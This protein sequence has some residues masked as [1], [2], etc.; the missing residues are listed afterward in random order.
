MKSYARWAAPAR[1]GAAFVASLLAAGLMGCATSLRSMPSKDS[2]AILHSLGGGV[3]DSRRSGKVVLVIGGAHGDEPSGAQAARRLAAAPP[4]RNGL[5]LVLP[6]ANP[7]ALAAGT[8]SA[9]T[10]GGADLNRLYPGDKTARLP[11]EPARAAAIFA[12][13][14]KADLVID[15]H[16]EG[17][18]WAEADLPT[19]VFSPPAAALV[20][21]LVQAA[22]A[23]GRDFVFT[24]GA[25]AGSLVGE[26][27]RAGRK[28]IL[29]EV[30]ARLPLEER[31]RLHLA[32]I[33]AC[34]VLLG[35]D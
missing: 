26:L 11:E 21:D 2:L 25:P 20:M 22:S 10:P 8:R 14:L 15:L 30:P 33:E 35:M 4:P 34:L 17:L 27:G 19:I 7:A 28:A 3:L 6:E 24:G 32:V 12:L 9:P 16:E 13:A 31:T 23:A 18:A 5:V 29:V 1:L